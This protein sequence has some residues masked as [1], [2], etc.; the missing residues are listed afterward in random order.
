MLLLQLLLLLGVAYV[1][2]DRI[3]VDFVLVLLF[4]RVLFFVIFFSP[5]LVFGSC[6]FSSCF[7]F[8]FF[9]LSLVHA[10]VL[11]PV[12]I[13]NSR[14]GHWHSSIHWRLVIYSSR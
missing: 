10:F 2:V 3:V 1:G 4:P 12:R 6:P 11:V 5:H 9:V 14:A 7:C 8:S 13:I